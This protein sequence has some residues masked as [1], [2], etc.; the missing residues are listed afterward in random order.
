MTLLTSPAHLFLLFAG[1][2][3]L[4]LLM[5]VPP[6]GGGDEPMHFERTYEVVTGN[7]LGTTEVPAGISLFIERSISI[8]KANLELGIPFGWEQ[9][10]ELHSIALQNNKIAPLPHP[11]RKI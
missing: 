3:G 6:F 7:F 11:E 9:F 10:R 4:A 1:V 2:F 8:V 5:L